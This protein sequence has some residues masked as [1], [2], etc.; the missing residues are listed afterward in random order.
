MNKVKKS[1]HICEKSVRVDYKRVKSKYT[2]TGI[3]EKTVHHGKTFFCI[4]APPH[5]N[6]KHSFR[7]DIAVGYERLKTY[8]SYPIVD[9]NAPCFL[10]KKTSDKKKIEKYEADQE[11]KVQAEKKVKEE[12][13]TDI[14][15]AKK[16]LAVEKEKKKKAIIARKKVVAKRKYQREYAKKK[17]AEKKLALKSEKEKVNYF[18]RFEILD[19]EEETL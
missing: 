6:Y 8:R 4:A 19:F 13:K 5:M 14:L 3:M 18:D 9:K 15:K 17:R 2:P 1:C 16:K 11:S 12:I 10:Y 7:G